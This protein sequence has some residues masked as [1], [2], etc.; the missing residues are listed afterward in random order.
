MQYIIIIILKLVDSLI[1]TSKSILVHKNKAKLVA[2]M[3][4]ISQ[5]LF[6]I[7]IAEVVNTNDLLSKIL[8][9]LSASVGAYLAFPINEKF[10]EDKTYVNIITAKNKENMEQLVEY[11]RDNHIKNIIIDTVTKQNE[12]TLA[13]LIF[14]KTKHE[15]RMID[16]YVDNNTNKLFRETW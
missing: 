3:I 4:F 5:L 10:S 2:V 16:M 1:S 13:V 11:L 14:C 12:R 15:S 9:A 8:V 6:Y 7:V